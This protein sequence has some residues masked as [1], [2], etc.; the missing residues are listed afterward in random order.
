MKNLILFSILFLS[1]TSFSQKPAIYGGNIEVTQ[2]GSN[3]FIMR[4]TVQIDSVNVTSMT[5]NA[6]DNA[7]DTFVK[8]FTISLD[9]SAIIPLRYNTFIF[10]SLYVNYLSDTFNIPNNPNGYYFVNTEF[11]KIKGLRNFNDGNYIFNCQIPDPAIPGGNSN[12][13][14]VNFD[15]SLYLRSGRESNLNFSCI[16][17]DG[18]SLH[19]SVFT[20][21]DSVSFIGGKPFSQLSFKTGFNLS[22]LVGPGARVYVNSNSGFVWVQFAFLGKYSTPIKCEEFRNGVKIGEVHRD[23]VLCGNI[24]YS[25]I[26]EIKLFKNVTIY[27]NPSNG[28]FTLAIEEFKDSEYNLNIIDVTGKTVHSELIYSSQSTINLNKV[29]KGIYFVQLSDGSNKVVKRIVIQ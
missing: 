23:L 19:Y 24:F 14:F 29:S 1:S 11:L 15:D 2:I 27:P 12:P 26:S 17:K 7:T 10:D 16:D 22:N 8:S 20:P 25:E 4:A 9:S 21:F 5:I 28:N 6:F 3:Q 13:R 18:D